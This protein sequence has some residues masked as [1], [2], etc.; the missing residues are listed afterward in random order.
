MTDTSIQT[1][2]SKFFRDEAAWRLK[3]YEVGNHADPR[4]WTAAQ[5]HIRLAI[6]IEGLPDNDPGIETLASFG[7]PA[8][9]FRHG[10]GFEGMTIASRL[11][12]RGTPTSP[13][14]RLPKENAMWGC[15]AAFV[16][17]AERDR[18]AVDRV[19]A[20]LA[21]LLD[22]TSR[23]RLKAALGRFKKGE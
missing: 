21:T 11:G 1:E 12:F 10:T 13:N 9:C 14:P 7:W 20:I 18:Y 23:S 22:D 5:W 3:K 4:E 15:W 19:L 8:E 6:F 2:L 17:A 16:S